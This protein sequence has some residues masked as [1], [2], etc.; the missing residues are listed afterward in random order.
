MQGS[1][2]NW[3]LAARSEQAPSLIL[4]G[5]RGSVE[6]VIRTF[7]LGEGQWGLG[8]DISLSVAATAVD[9]KPLYWST[10]AGE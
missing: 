2:A 9:G 7:E 1:D 4:A 5:L 8:F 3:L 6:P 10:G